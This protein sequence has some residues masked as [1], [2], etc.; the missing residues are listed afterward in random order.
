MNLCKITLVFNRGY[1]IGLKWLTIWLVQSITLKIHEVSDSSDSQFLETMQKLIC[2]L[3]KCFANRE[4]QTANS[5]PG[6]WVWC[7]LGFLPPQNFL[8]SFMVTCGRN[9]CF[10]AAFYTLETSCL[11]D[12]LWKWFKWFMACNRV[13]TPQQ[14]YLSKSAILQS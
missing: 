8:Q 2:K 14:K 11:R 3:P 13:L 12:K 10:H 1:L 7:V 6:A 9:C 5:N 4:L